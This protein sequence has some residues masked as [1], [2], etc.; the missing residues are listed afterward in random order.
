[1]N[2]FHKYTE[3]YDSYL[4]K[5]TLDEKSKDGTLAGAKSRQEAKVCFSRPIVYKHASWIC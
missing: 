4:T 3:R 1:M 5:T 2:W